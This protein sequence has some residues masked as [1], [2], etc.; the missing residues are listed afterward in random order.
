MF[1]PLKG[2]VE[3]LTKKRW[4]IYLPSVGTNSDGGIENGQIEVAIRPTNLNL[5]NLEAGAGLVVAS[6]PLGYALY[7]YEQRKEEEEAKLKKAKMAAKKAAK[8]KAAAA[9]NSK[10]TPKKEEDGSFFMDNAAEE[11]EKQPPT[12]KGQESKGE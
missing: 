9:K 5:S 3:F 11:G 7:N 4:R 1:S 2:W 12:M 6:Y 8:A 10:G